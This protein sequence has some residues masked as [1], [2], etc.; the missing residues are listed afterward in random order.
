MVQKITTACTGTEPTTLI[1]AIP[2]SHQFILASP[3]PN[4]IL[5]RQYLDPTVLFYSCLLFINFLWNVGCWWWRYSWLEAI[6]W[7]HATIHLKA[8]LHHHLSQTL[9]LYWSASC[10]SSPA[11]L[12]NICVSSQTLEK[13]GWV[14]NL[15][16]FHFLKYS[17]FNVIKFLTPWSSFTARYANMKV[18]VCL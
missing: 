12:V 14:I 4:C 17:L 13:K 8:F 5:C 10:L 16:P 6:S 2:H 7:S 18:C 11:S 15:I 9:S 3:M 1:L